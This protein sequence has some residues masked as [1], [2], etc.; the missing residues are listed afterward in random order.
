MHDMKKLNES[1]RIENI[2]LNKSLNKYQAL[3][4]HARYQLT[5]PKCIN[6]KKTMKILEV[7]V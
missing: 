6:K 7:N 1:H 2:H 4:S 3:L 5:Q